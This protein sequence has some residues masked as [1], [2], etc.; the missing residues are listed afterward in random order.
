MVTTEGYAN[1]PG[2]A[3]AKFLAEVGESEHKA[4]R[5]FQAGRQPA[6]PGARDLVN[7]FT[8]VENE[9]LQDTT[10]PRSSTVTKR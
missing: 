3:Q 2:G 5:D 4:F 1:R 7:F 10:A 9:L 8:S 6:G